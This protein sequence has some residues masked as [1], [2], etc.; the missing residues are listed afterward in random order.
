[1][2]TNNLIRYEISFKFD[3][4]YKNRFLW[5]KYHTLIMI[6]LYFR[7]VTGPQRLTDCYIDHALVIVN[8]ILS[9]WL[10]DKWMDLF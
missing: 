1:M 5:P 4:L 6:C 7:L 8:I 2:S 3:F 10:K 9:M